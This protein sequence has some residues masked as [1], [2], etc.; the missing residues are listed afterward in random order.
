[1]E[2]I[3]LFEAFLKKYKEKCHPKEYIFITGPRIN[4]NFWEE[5]AK[6]LMEEHDM[7]ELMRQIKEISTELVTKYDV[8][9][10]DIVVNEDLGGKKSVSIGITY[11]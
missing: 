9:D 1:M 2:E 4:K 7:E 6:E 10:I 3:D 11:E 8:T 5:K